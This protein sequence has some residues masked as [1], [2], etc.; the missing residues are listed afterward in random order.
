MGAA[1]LAAAPVGA[2]SARGRASADAPNTFAAFGAS[3]PVDPEPD[4]AALGTASI[5]AGPAADPVVTAAMASIAGPFDDAPSGAGDAVLEGMGTGPL[6]ASSE[7]C[8]W[9]SDPLTEPAPP[10][11][12]EAVLRTGSGALSNKMRG[13]IQMA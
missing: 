9:E 13:S 8:Y 4:I 12:G 11:A 1:E 5:G 10:E 7:G 3:A 2:G 6:A